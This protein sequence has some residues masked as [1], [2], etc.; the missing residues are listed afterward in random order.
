MQHVSLYNGHFY[1]GILD[2]AGFKT[3][4]SMSS[5]WI[6]LDTKKLVVLEFANYVAALLWWLLGH[7][8]AVAK[9]L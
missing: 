1:S 9:E 3:A 2:K 7:F 8:Y 4:K 6:C 5:K